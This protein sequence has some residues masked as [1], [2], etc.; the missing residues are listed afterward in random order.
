MGGP[1]IEFPDCF[2]NIC[3]SV[4]DSPR[5]VPTMEVYRVELVSTQGRVI[6]CGVG[7]CGSIFAGRNSID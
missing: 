7:G 5:A 4:D 3:E 2:L 1:E 6:L